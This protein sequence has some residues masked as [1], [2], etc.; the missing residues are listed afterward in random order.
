MKHKNF[1]FIRKIPL[2]KTYK[3]EKSDADNLHARLEVPGLNESAS[4]HW[5]EELT[6]CKWNRN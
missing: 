5:A 3:N 6:L 1:L 4:N 2:W